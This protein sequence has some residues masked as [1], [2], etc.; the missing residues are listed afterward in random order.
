MNS[1]EIQKI[2]FD[3]AFSHVTFGHNDTDTSMLQPD[4][5]IA[6]LCDDDKWYIG[7]IMD[8]CNKNNYV[9]VKFMRGNS[10]C[11]SWYDHDNN[12]GQSMFVPFQ[13]ILCTVAEPHLHSRSM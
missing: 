8:R 3:D 11:S 2:Y 5:Y 1:K 7:I 13:H 9:K 12:C 10:L 6:C 4:R